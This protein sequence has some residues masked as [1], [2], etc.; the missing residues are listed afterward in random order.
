[1]GLEVHPQYASQ[2]HWIEGHSHLKSGAPSAWNLQEYKEAS[3]KD[4]LVERPNEGSTRDTW[5]IASY[6]DRVQI[7]Q[8]ENRCSSLHSL[9][10]VLLLLSQMMRIPANKTIPHVI[11]SGCTI[12]DDAG[13]VT[14]NVP[15]SPSTS[16]VVP[17]GSSTTPVA[18]TGGAVKVIERVIE[19]AVAETSKI[20]PKPR[21]KLSVLNQSLL[22][23]LIELGL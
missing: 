19:S 14:T 18:R 10:P 4:L 15:V 17:L 22:S 8:V 5:G 23:T 1:V 6:I 9:P 7:Y 13:R 20:K 16:I 2:D 11:A 12:G 3:L 21:L